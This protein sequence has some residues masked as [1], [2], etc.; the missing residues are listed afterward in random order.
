VKEEEEEEQ[1]DDIGPVYICLHL[2]AM[3]AL[4]FL[5]KLFP[6]CISS[7]DLTELEES[8]ASHSDTLTA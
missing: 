5:S 3:R 7:P 1:A 8:S 4:I 2:V 6:C